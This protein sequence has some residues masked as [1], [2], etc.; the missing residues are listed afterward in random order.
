MNIIGIAACTAGIAHT[1]IAKEKLITAAKNAGHNIHIETQG[2]IGVQDEIPDELI[3]SA[4]IVILAI[5]VKVSGRERFA[6]KKIIEV[7][8]EIAIKSPNKLI[9]KIEEAISQ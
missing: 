7:P 5:D 9:K 6:D 8:T 3:E 4:D 2:T 1:Y